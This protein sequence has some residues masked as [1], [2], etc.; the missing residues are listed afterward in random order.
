MSK[1][2]TFKNYTFHRPLQHINT[3]DWQTLQMKFI[4]IKDVNRV[5]TRKVMLLR[6]HGENMNYLLALPA[7]PGFKYFYSQTK[8]FKEK[9]SLYKALSSKPHQFTTESILVN[10]HQSNFAHR[11]RQKSKRT[12]NPR[13]YE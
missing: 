5:K 10:T 9:V 2:Y 12:S 3:T 7:D 8:Y 13:L 4:Y 1:S 6:L 11:I